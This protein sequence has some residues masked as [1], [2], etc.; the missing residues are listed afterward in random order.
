[1]HKLQRKLLGAKLRQQTNL[2]PV[3]RN[4]ARWSSTYQ[5]LIRY[6]EIPINVSNYFG[7]EGFLIDFLTSPR[8]NNE[9]DRVIQKLE[10]ID[11]V[12]IALQKDSLDKAD[13]R[14]LLDGIK[15]PYPELDPFNKYLSD[16]A[17]IRKYPPFELG[18]SYP[19]RR[20]TF[21]KIQRGILV[22]KKLWRRSTIFPINVNK[23]LVTFWNLI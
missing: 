16:T 14:S 17:T 12:T 20:A 7:N 21:L 5:M 18:I 3:C 2:L 23:F 8:E 19:L 9:I 22:Q 6:S 10:G 15:E 11:M 1:M 4:V 13:A